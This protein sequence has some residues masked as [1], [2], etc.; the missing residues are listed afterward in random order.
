MYWGLHK[1]EKKKQLFGEGCAACK[2]L[3]FSFV[4]LFH[5]V[6]QH[7]I[8]LGLDPGEL[9]EEETEG[10][11]SHSQVKEAQRS[12]TSED[13]A[14]ISQEDRSLKSIGSVGDVSKVRW[15]SGLSLKDIQEYVVPTQ[16]GKILNLSTVKFKL[17]NINY[18]LALFSG[19]NQSSSKFT[20][21]G[22]LA[23][24]DMTQYH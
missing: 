9:E 23:R 5:Q 7:S 8:L 16:I 15:C 4:F 1:E 22:L 20:L 6:L 14:H 17:M 2:I 21:V 12:S 19:L 11:Q 24:K 13:T 10:T 3:E 18:T